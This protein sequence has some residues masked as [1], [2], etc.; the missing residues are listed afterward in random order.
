MKLAVFGATG[1]VGSEIVSQAL[2]R[3]DEVVAYVRTPASLAPQPGLT[4]I[5][6]SVT[7]AA[8]MTAA[9]LGVDAV[10]SAIGGKPPLM[11]NALPQI[12]T[13]IT[14]AGVGRF[15]LVSA[16]GVGA[17]KNKASSF[18]R[19]I[20]STA[21]KSLFEDKA[22]SEAAVLPSLAMNWT[23]VYPVNLKK[24][25]PVAS[26]V[27]DLAAVSKVPGLPTLPFA[28]VAAAVLD[29]AADDAASGKQMLITTAAGWRA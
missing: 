8:A 2:S 5:G 17:T 4:I 6:G 3:G 10:V 22:K 16:F 1:N 23:V 19:L 11:Q 9:F 26:A 29:L 14:Q 18:A 25:I 21:V 7:D 12:A 27:K 13:A 28:N 24:G 20:Y 15:V